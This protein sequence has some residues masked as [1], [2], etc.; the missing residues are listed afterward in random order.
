MKDWFI[1]FLVLWPVV[2]TRKRAEGLWQLN[3]G[4]IALQRG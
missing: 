4:T 3:I 2:L 1:E